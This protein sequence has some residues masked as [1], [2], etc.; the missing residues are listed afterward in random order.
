MVE[1]RPQQER[2]SVVTGNYYRNSDG[3]GRPV[4]VALQALREAPREGGVLGSATARRN[5]PDVPRAADAD[6]GPNRLFTC[7]YLL[8]P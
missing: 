2:F 1:P 4:S 7:T 3:R 6:D 5:T 8:C